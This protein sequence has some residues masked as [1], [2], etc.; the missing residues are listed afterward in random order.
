MSGT[1]GVVG[2]AVEISLNGI[3]IDKG[4][5][6]L[7]GRFHAFVKN[8]SITNTKQVFQVTAKNSKHEEKVGWITKE[9]NM[10]EAEATIFMEIFAIVMLNISD[11]KEVAQRQNCFLQYNKTNELPVESNDLGFIYIKDKKL[12]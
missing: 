1:K 7:N 12:L 8:T 2:L 3:T 10:N 9:A 4:H 11:S 6:D 5:S